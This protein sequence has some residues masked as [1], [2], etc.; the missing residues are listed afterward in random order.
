[1][2]AWFPPKGKGQFWGISCQTE[3]HYQQLLRNV[4][5]CTFTWCRCGTMASVSIYEAKGP[6][7]KLLPIWLCCDDVAFCQ[8]I[9]FV[10]LLKLPSLI[11]T[12]IRTKWLHSKLTAF[13]T[14]WNIV[15]SEVLSH[16]CTEHKNRIYKIWVP[17][18]CYL[19]PHSRLIEI[20]IAIISHK[21]LFQSWLLKFSFGLLIINILVTIVF[22][23]RISFHSTFSWSLL[24]YLLVTYRIVYILYVQTTIT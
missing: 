15:I 12:V 20:L 4:V 19:L 6:R 22:S 2:G 5:H 24:W 7:W 1:M 16:N 11:S 13:K 8:I 23:L 9:Y 21:Q 17:I 18:Q 10:L 3:K 14:D